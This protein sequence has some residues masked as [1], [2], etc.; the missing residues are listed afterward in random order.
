MHAAMVISEQVPSAAQQA[1]TGW[2]Q[3]TSP[4]P[5]DSPTQVPPEASQSAGTLPGLWP[6]AP[7][8]RYFRAGVMFTKIE[9]CFNTLPHGQPRVIGEV[10]LP[11]V[12]PD[13]RQDLP[14]RYAGM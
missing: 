6:R 7:L 12:V 13:G 5:A 11:H 9:P 8:Q 3:S 1:P 14:D 10:S 4:Q 2:L